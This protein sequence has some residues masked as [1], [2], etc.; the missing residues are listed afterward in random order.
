MTKI[1]KHDLRLGHI[2][3]CQVCGS[4]DLQAIIDLGYHPPCDS[5]LTRPQL[6]EAERFYP[7]NLVRC[8]VC[9]LVQID[10][11]VDPTVVFHPDYPY[12]SGITPTLVSFLQRIATDLKS[13]YQL[14]KHSLVVDIGSN[15]GTLLQGFKNLGMRILGVEPTNI[16]DIAN[17]REIPTVKSFFSEDV[18]KTILKK[19]GKA[20]V[21]TATNMFAHVQLLGSMIRGVRD[22]L[23]DGGIFLTESHYLSS[24]LETVQY[25]SVYHE[26]LKYYSLKP[27]IKLFK[28][29]GF[30]VTDAERIPNYGGSIRVVARK[31]KGHEVS[32]RLMDLVR[33]EEKAGVYEE[34]AY[35]TFRNR[36]IQSKID[37]QA[38]L[39]DLK[40][41]GH[42][43]PGIG[44]P[45]RSSTLLNYC[46]VDPE[47]MPYIAE[48]STCLKVGLY[49]PGKHIPIIDEKTLLKENPSYCV[50]LSWHYAAPIIRNLRKKGLTSKIIMPLPHVHIV[51]D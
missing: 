46:N 3:S 14:K 15:D 37:L 21:V 10:Y 5:L 36:I 20:T 7:L 18:S 47:L 19:H 51:E 17:E 28:Y 30:V 48:Q 32:D 13:R 4:R 2:V 49:L 27:L 43:V 8:R 23:E 11:V 9:G 24:I 29:Y 45:G 41:K 12:Q 33:E 39:L 31:G 1:P 34:E 50:M 16:A 6:W 40:R 35:V 44:C 25:D 22:M 42:R 26:H 38:M